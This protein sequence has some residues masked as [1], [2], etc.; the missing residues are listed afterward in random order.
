MVARKVN[1]R[2]WWLR[3]SG[4]LLVF[5]DWYRK[6]NPWRCEH[7]CDPA[8]GKALDIIMQERHQ[9]VKKLIGELRRLAGLWRSHFCM[10]K[11]LKGPVYLP[12]M[13]ANLPM[14]EGG[15][16]SSTPW[17]K[18]IQRSHPTAIK[19][20]KL[21]EIGLIKMARQGQGKFA[22]IYSRVLS[23]LSFA[24]KS[25]Q[26]LTSVSRRIWL[27]IVKKMN[28]LTLKTFHL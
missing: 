13:R 19:F 9:E 20:T 14:I 25:C 7:Y 22:R 8:S 28:F 24:F 21:A 26:I 6:E 12:S 16:S 18:D 2:P 3:L 27:L 5:E 17:S 4:P 11:C 1:L 23:V 10:L 15:S